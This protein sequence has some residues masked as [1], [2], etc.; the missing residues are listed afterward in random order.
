MNDPHERDKAAAQIDFASM[1]LFEL[2][3]AVINASRDVNTSLYRFSDVSLKNL[4]ADI[5]KAHVDQV[6]AKELQV[7]VQFD[8]TVP[9]TL[10]IQADNARL[11]FALQILY[12]NALMYTHRGGSVLVYASID[13]GA[14][15]LI[16]Q[17]TDDGIG[18]KESDL[19]HV[20]SRFFRATN[21]RRMD[22][23]GMGLGLYIAKDIIEK[24]GGRIWAESGGEN[25]GSKFTVALTL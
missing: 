16:I 6:M 2:T 15:E 4:L 13:A 22:T 23:E 3:N 12:E 24:H 5:Q 17:F 7:Q 11:R 9:E 25:K 1:R 14:N 10:E 19:P 21:A 8:S 18:I 20:F